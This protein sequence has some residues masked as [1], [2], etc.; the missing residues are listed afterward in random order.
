[1]K[2]K[3]LITGGCGFIGHH[4]VE[5]F[6][7]N[8]DWNIVVLDCL[9]YASNG[10]D[11]L[12]DINCFD[13]NRVKVLTANL[14]EAVSVGILQE[15]GKVDYLVNLASESHVDNSIDHPVPFIKNNIAL[16]VHVLSLAMQC[17]AKK[18]IQFSTDEVYGPAHGNTAF[19]EGDRFNPGNPYAASKAAQEAICISYA[20][21]Y[22]LPIMITNT[23]NVMGERQHPE[24][25]IPMVIR[26]VLKGEV[27]TI[28]SDAEKKNAGSR[29]Y[30]HAR[31]VATAVYF[32]LRNIDEPLDKIDASK[33]KFNIVGEVE[34]D[35]LTLAQ[36]IA[37][38]L[39]SDLKYEMVDFHSSRPGHD[40]RYAL[41]G[42]KLNN[43]RWNVPV[44][45]DESLRKTVLWEAARF[46]EGSKI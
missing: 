26:K 37:D 39:C 32:I 42:R 8:T 36:K 44:D 29:F 4:F 34:V 12:R 22:G 18:I 15:I 16:M 28:H 2:T 13:S 24:K 7:K 20:N 10:F 38:I 43:L 45:F 46:V 5:F 23:M 6:I 33:G 31:N 14:S 17:K 41:D 19:K 27:V 35:N 30:I 9:T 11:R 1:M 25:F 3:I 40:L 21:S